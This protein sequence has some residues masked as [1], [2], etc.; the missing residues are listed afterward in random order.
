MIFKIWLLFLCLVSAVIASANG[1]NKDCEI[2]F[3]VKDEKLKY[4]YS[5]TITVMVKVKL[6]E[7]FC[8]EAA[9]ATKIFSRGLKIENRSE[10]KKISETTVGQK[11]VLT[12]LKKGTNKT[13][14]VYRKNAHYNC[15][16]QL[17]FNIED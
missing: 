15:F 5:D 1:G 4:N 13:L 12:V 14:T 9:D 16:E 10:W 2:S 11:L 17:E 6:D 7:E 3:S 8:D